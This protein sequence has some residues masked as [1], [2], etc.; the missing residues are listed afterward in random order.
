MVLTVARV[1]GTTGLG[2]VDCHPG[3]PLGGGAE[4]LPGG[5]GGGELLVVGAGGGGGGVG[6][7][8]CDEEKERQE[9]FHPAAL[10]VLRAWPELSNT[11]AMFASLLPSCSHKTKVQLFHNYYR[12]Y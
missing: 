10:S 9:V 6:V 2:A 11:C 1:A 4:C 7:G 3:L 5:A 12:F 8:Y